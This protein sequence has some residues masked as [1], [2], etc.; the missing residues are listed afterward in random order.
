M[1]V[2]R[3]I[4]PGMLPAT[5]SFTASLEA[6]RLMRPLSMFA[7]LAAESGDELVERQPAGRAAHSHHVPERP[8]AGQGRGEA[9]WRLLHLQDMGRVAVRS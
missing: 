6:Q 9:L 1:L 5:I 2:L 4:R 7:L 8:A 3:S